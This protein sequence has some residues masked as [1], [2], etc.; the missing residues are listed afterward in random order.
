MQNNARSLVTKMVNALTAKLEISSPMA[1]M[2]LL[3][4]P[5]HEFV[6]FYWK[7]FFR[8][9]CSVFSTPFEEIDS[10][11]DRVMLNKSK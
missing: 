1:S 8:E 5:G 7:T 9:A 3:G 10:I 6:N 11:P 4:N 2:Y